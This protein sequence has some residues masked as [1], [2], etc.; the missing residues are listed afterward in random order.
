[1]ELTPGT[2]VNA[3][4]RLVRPLGEGAM[5]TVWVAEHLT[6]ATQVAV[7]FIASELARKSPEIVARFE[8]EAS[9]AAKLRSPHVVQ[10]FDRG[11]TEDGTPYIVMELLEGESLQSHLERVGTLTLEETVLVVGQVGRALRRAHEAGIVHRDIKP[12]NIF[13]V[14]NDDEMFCKVLDFGIAKQ[15]HLPKLGG[16]TNPGMMIGTPEF[17]SP[18]QLLSSKDVDHHA[19][20]WALSVTAYYCLT[21]ALPFS[22]EALGALCVELLKGEFEPPTAFCPELP[23]ALDEFFARAMA[24]AS[25]DRF[26]DVRSLTAAF[27]NIVPGT[28]PLETTA[29]IGIRMSRTAMRRPAT[30][31]GLGPPKASRDSD[32]A[33]LR[34]AGDGPRSSGPVSGAAA[35]HRNANAAAT[36]GGKN[37]Y[38]TQASAEPRGSQRG[39]IAP[40]SRRSAPGSEDEVV[41]GAAPASLRNANASAPDSRTNRAS[42]RALAILAS[43]SSQKGYASEP[44][45]GGAASANS[46]PRG[47]ASHSAEELVVDALDFGDHGDAKMHANGADRTPSAAVK[48]HVGRAP[49]TLT[50]AASTT[51]S[52]PPPS[53]EKRST[54]GKVRLAAAVSLIAVC[55]AIFAFTGGTKEPSAQPGPRTGPSRPLGPITNAS[56]GERVDPRLEGSPSGDHSLVGTAKS[57]REDVPDVAV[58]PPEQPLK[59]SGR[60]TA[61]LSSD[62]SSLPGTSRAPAAVPS[63][64]VVPSVA[65]SVTASVTASATATPTPG[66]KPPVVAPPPTMRGDHGF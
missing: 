18:E 31:V 37:S 46:Q 63:A 38:E 42:A 17:M 58:K 5:G 4:L 40:A 61:A 49:T 30:V 19:D 55:A 62:A 34:D 44:Q 54:S 59:P 32:A 26:P 8:R 28:D 52:P 20:L 51:Q 2:L 7:K 60:G 12:D 50:G 65:A 45:T 9:V 13:L 1:M 43:V 39:A 15:G 27:A 36:P 64:V 22:A 24:K 6:L 41:L 11:I 3:N 14:Q 10:T 16:L 21:G 25:S 57:A 47:A 35:S 56:R 33:W 48:R 29:S 53:S 66:K 23:P